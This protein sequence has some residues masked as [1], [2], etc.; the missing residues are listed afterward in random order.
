M[1]TSLDPEGVAEKY[2]KDMEVP[3]KVVRIADFGAFVELEDGIE[4]LIHIS[5]IS[6]Q[7]RNPRKC[8][9][10]SGSDLQECST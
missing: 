9:R 8:F 2:R 4:G 6:Q 5:Q 10:G 7:R 1:A 3:V